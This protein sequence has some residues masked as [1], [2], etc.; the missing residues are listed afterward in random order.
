MVDFTKP[1]L[2]VADFVGLKEDTNQ[3]YLGAGALLGGNPFTSST[4]VATSYV[5]TTGAPE[6]PLYALLGSFLLLMVLLKLLL[7]P[8]GK[9]SVPYAPSSV[10]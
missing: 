10:R 9:R 1:G 8:K 5:V 7:H 2:T 6:T 4:Y 3:Y